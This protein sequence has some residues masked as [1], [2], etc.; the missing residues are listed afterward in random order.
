[1]FDIDVDFEEIEKITHPSVKN[2]AHQLRRNGYAITTDRYISLKIRNKLPEFRE[3]QNPRILMA[4]DRRSHQ[5]IISIN[6]ALTNPDKELERF[7]KKM[8]KIF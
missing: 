3:K 2:I 4:Q 5:K 8:I 6:P 7:I 1:M